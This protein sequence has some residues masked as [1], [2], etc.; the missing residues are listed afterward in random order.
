MSAAKWNWNAE[1]Y[2]KNSTAQLAW[3]QELIQKLGL[4]GHESVLD[5]GC[6]DGKISAQIAGIVQNGHVTGIDL[7]ESMMRLA[8]QKF[9][10]EAYPNL[11]FQC[12]DATK[13][14]FTE[15]FDVVFSNAALH[16]VRDHKAVLQGIHSC[17]K[18]NGKILLQ[19]GGRGNAAEI[20]ETVKR[21]ILKSAWKPFFQNFIPPYHFYGCEEYSTWLPEC[22]FKPSRVELIPKDMQH[23]NTDGLLGWIRTTWFPFTDCL[24]VELREPFLT[25]IVEAYTAVIPP[26]AEGHTHVNMVRLEVEALAM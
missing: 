26:D 6:G 17:L 15:K 5:I 11:V 18:T 4:R 14:H 2:A 24:P 10:P 7:S 13:I 20:I 22:G 23:Q 19:M 12:M 8:S 25:E 9:P 1:D 21:I 3:A 16:W